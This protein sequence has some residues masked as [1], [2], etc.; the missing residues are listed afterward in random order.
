[1][2]GVCVRVCVCVCVFVGECGI[3]NMF[4]FLWGAK[5]WRE[6]WQIPNSRANKEMKKK[7][8]I[9]VKC[10]EANA[11]LTT[12]GT[13]EGESC[14]GLQGLC[15]TYIGTPMSTHCVRCLNTWH[16]WHVGMPLLKGEPLENQNNIISE[17]NASSVS[18]WEDKLSVYQSSRIRYFDLI[19]QNI[20]FIKIKIQSLTF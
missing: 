6:S 12:S 2:G 19:S 14:G 17:R 20:S 7:R 8:R 10:V 11:S 1:M 16:V 15:G 4:V 3:E 13:W 9:K 18:I 5:I